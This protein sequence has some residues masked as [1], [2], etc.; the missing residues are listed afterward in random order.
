M[1]PEQIIF[2]KYD[3][4]YLLIGL[5]LI[6]LGICI[7][8][9]LKNKKAMAN[10]SIAEGTVDEELVALVANKYELGRD[11]N[12]KKILLNSKKVSRS[13]AFIK[14]RNGK[15]YVIDNNSLN[16]T[17]L[18]GS[19]LNTSVMYKLENNDVILIGGVPLKF[20]EQTL[21]TESV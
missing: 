16:G 18:N 19:K 21:N 8:Q 10:L 9:Y 15:F 20:I 7:W 1:K 11:D 13:H 2:P 17:Y 5:I 3:I 12:S 6:G 14:K 4:L